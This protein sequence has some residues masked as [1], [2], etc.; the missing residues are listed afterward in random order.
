MIPPVKVK[1][2]KKG[3]VLVLR[4]SGRLDALS[5]EETERTV[6]KLITNGEHQVLFDF[7]GVDYLS[8]AGMRMLLAAYKKLKSVSGK[9]AVCSVGDGV[10]DI[11]KMSGFDEILNVYSEEEEALK[12]FQP[13]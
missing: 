1:Q 4:I 13:G 5:S 7:T 6:T 8:S 12:V 3:K 11:L 9:M 2:E 10:M